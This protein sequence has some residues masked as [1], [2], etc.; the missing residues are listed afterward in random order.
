MKKTIGLCFVAL[1]LAMAGRAQAPAA[2]PVVMTI[3]GKDVPK[4]EFAYYYNKNGK[5]NCS[6]SDYVDLFINYRLKVD[7]ALAEHLDTLQSFKDEFA[8][9]RDKQLQ[10]FL[11]DSL[12]EDSIALGVYSRMEQQIGDSDLIK[13]AHIFL[14]LPQK[15]SPKLVQTKQACIDSIYALLQGGADFAELA[16]KCSEDYSTAAGGGELPWIGPN[17]AIKEFETV[18]YSLKPGQY[19]KPFQSAIGLHIIK[20][21]DRKKLEPYAEKRDEIIKLLKAQGLDDMAFRH[22]VEQRLAASNGTL[23]REELMQQ[24]L[25][26][27]AAEHPELRPLVKEYHDGL[28]LFEVMKRDVW[29]PAE[30]DTAGL[31]AFFKKNRKNYSWTSPR[32][33]GFV[34][35]CKEASQTEEAKKILKKNEHKDWAGAIRSKFNSEKTPQVIVTR[36]IFKQGDNAFVDHEYFSGEEPKAN[37]RYPYTVLIGKLLKKGPEEFDDVRGQ[38]VSDYQEVKEKEWTKRLRDKAQIQINKEVLSQ[39]EGL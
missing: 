21:D 7:K 11:I 27:H 18:A 31:E 16:R 8:T 33:K 23:T 2:D 14:S 10:P 25:N 6:L 9:Y 32:F 1:A 20:M 3:N 36:K 29:N 30:Q 26:S 34:V 5:N 19:S 37:K 15:A 28:L 12:Y 24:V 39:M 22:A 17:Q 38:V 13:V 35:H 4:S